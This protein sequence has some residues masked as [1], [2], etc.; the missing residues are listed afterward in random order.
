M[1]TLETKAISQE[2]AGLFETIRAQA[3]EYTSLMLQL[4][5]TTEQTSLQTQILHNEY[6]KLQKKTQVILGDV[7]Q[8]SQSALKVISDKSEKI[9]IVYRELDTIEMIKNSLVD[10]GKTLVRQRNDY[11]KWQKE[12]ESYLQK[13]SSESYSTMEGRVAFQFQQIKND[14]HNFD[15]RLISLLDLHRRDTRN[16]H[17]D[18]DDFKSK[19]TETKYIVDETTKLVQ[20]MISEAER[21]IG[22]MI[23]HGHL[24]VDKKIR[25]STVPEV[26]TDIFER[27]IGELQKHSVAQREKIKVLENRT[28]S[29]I[30]SVMYGAVASIAI[31][32]IIFVLLRSLLQ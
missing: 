7:Q 14:M 30:K 13:I 6:E 10:L 31:S 19:V 1:A 22:S 4:R 16:I 20:D 28:S 17:G 26:Q 32:V 21:N 15:Q 8:N 24:E 27:A 18:I 12:S 11:E 9:D 25:D 2:V 29:V 5:E 3:A 23:A